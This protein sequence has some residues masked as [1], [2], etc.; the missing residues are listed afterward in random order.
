MRNELY[1]PRPDP[2]D[3]EVQRL[4]HDLLT[5]AAILE[6]FKRAPQDLLAE[7]NLD[8]E[9][10]SALG[11]NEFGV[12]RSRG[13]HP[14]LLI[15]VQ[16]LFAWELPAWSAAPSKKDSEQPSLGQIEN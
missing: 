10:R 5:D 9:I 12:L 11:D 1:Y 16:R 3:Y 8:A 13:V 4:V 15:Q 7:Y 2:N 6:R 14:I